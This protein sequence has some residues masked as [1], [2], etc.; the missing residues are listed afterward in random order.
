MFRFR[1]LIVIGF[2]ASLLMTGVGMIVPLLPQRVMDLSGSLQST[3][4]I[5]ST[6]ALAYLLV[7]LPL[8]RLADR[9]GVK[10]FLLL[11]YLF[12]AAAGVLFFFAG[13]DGALFFGRFIQ[14]I[15]EAPIWALGPALLSL[16]YPREKGRVIGLYNAA[17]HVGLTAGPLL[18]LLLFP[19]RESNLPFL[20]F[21][22]LCGLG[23]VTL[24]L[25]L[26]Q[27]RGPRIAQPATLR[28]TVALLKLR[29]PLVTLS[30][31]L[32]YGAGYGV[33]I[34]VLPASLAVTQ[35]F[36]NL[37]NGVLFTLFYGAISL[38][39]IVV[40]PL[41]DRHG[42][43][44]YMVAGLMM[45]AVGFAVFMA[46]AQPW[47]YL[48]LVGASLGLGVF[49]VA[50]MAYLNDC[51]PVSLKGTISG[52]YY[53]AWGCGYFLGPVMVGGLGEAGFIVLAALFAVQALA[54]H[55]SRPLP[56]AGH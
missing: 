15:G 22:A 13:S 32:L 56:V 2:A 18:G 23:A 37:S 16:A 33:F 38:A 24:L 1:L 31:I 51:V 49:C 20:A 54:Q 42:R 36:D 35:G 45:S 40:G 6:F 14:G 28:Q 41:T 44:G 46:V 26:P 52:S 30:G 4:L 29:G 27:Q 7:Q 5:A 34:S 39:Q 48:P 55:R 47:T 10:P 17:I 43:H 8:G 9:L 25:F 11:G 3:G 50:S 12:C 21:A 53:L 19:A